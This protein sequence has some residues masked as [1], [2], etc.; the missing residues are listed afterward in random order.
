MS[1]YLSQKEGRIGTPE[2]PLSEGGRIL[3]LSYWKD[4]CMRTL[5]LAACPP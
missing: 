2:T 4:V 1:Y 3:Y 5:L